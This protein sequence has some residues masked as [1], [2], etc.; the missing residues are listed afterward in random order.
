MTLNKRKTLLALLIACVFLLSA[1]SG[2]SLTQ[3]Q[4]TAPPVATAVAT[5]LPTAVP[6]QDSSG[7]LTMAEFLG[8]DMLGDDEDEDE[9]AQDAAIDALPDDE[10]IPAVNGNAPDQTDAPAVTDAPAPTEQPATPPP[11]AVP[12]E[13]PTPTPEPTATPANPFATT[14]PEGE[15]IPV[16][17]TVK[18][19]SYAA[20]TD[21]SFG[22]V[23]NYPIDWIN[24]PGKYTV[25]FEEPEPATSFPARVAVTRKQLA[26]KPK[27]KA[28]Y[29]QFQAYA[30][31]IY[32]QYDPKTFEYDD[33]NS[34]GVFMGHQ[35]YEVTYLAYSDKVEV[36]GYLCCC[37]I[38]KAIYVF[39]FCCPYDEY[40]AYA[41]AILQMRD[42]VASLEDED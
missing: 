3:P 30:Q 32:E 22:F 20:L 36:E 1:C 9:P 6:R 28:V 39:H 4:R 12:T 17:E 37:S 16:V 26:H 2:G 41:E 23:M 25:C 19:L 15:D 42:S 40:D 5:L 11:T 27:A 18:S 31:M 13:A 7:L 8:V 35:A 29:T 14:A 10:D 33:V 38:G 21:P 24:L 34:N